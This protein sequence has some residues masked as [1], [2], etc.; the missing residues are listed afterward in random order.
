MSGSSIGV[1]RNAGAIGIPVVPNIGG[2][3]ILV[4]PGSRRATTADHAPR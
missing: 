4:S 3:G 1:E 2:D